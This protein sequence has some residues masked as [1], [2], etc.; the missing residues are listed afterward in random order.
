MP[1]NGLA[2]AVRVGCQKDVVSVLD[3]LGD[4]IDV[5]LVALDQLV[6]HRKILRGIDSTGLRHQIP[7][8]AVA[9][10]DLERVSQV[11]LQRSSL[12]LAASAS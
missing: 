10:Q 12:F 8:V 11:L 9:R 5:L 1:G 6:L 3:G 7:H 4:G 2:F